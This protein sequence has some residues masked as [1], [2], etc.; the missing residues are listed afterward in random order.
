MERD[1]KKNERRYQLKFISH[2]GNIDRVNEN[3]ENNPNYIQKALDLGYDVEID[4]RLIDENL[5][6]GHDNPDFEVSLDFLKNE[7]LWCHAK[8]LD[9]L[10]FMIKEEIQCFWHQEDDYTITSKGF[11]W[12]YPG[13]KLFLK[14]ICVLPEKFNYKKIKCSGICSDFIEKYN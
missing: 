7:K 10:D 3:L 11:I 4:V 12:T 5:F 9:A 6:L 8:N 13:K 2:R 1:N 14:S